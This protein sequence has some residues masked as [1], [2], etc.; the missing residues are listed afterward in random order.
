MRMSYAQ[1][2]A[3]FLKNHVLVAK[4]P[5]GYDLVCNERV[6]HVSNGFKVV[7]LAKDIKD[8]DGSL[9]AKN[10]ASVLQGLVE[11]RDESKM[12]FNQLKRME[13]EIDLA[14]RMGL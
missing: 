10:V 5:D 13:S 8:F 2:C 1:A 12:S 3:I 9:S 11:E 14:N 4:A 7:S 6:F